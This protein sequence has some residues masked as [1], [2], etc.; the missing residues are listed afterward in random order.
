MAVNIIKAAFK[1]IR[2]ATGAILTFATITDGQVLTRSGN[3]I[4]STASVPPS[5]A[6]GGDLSGTYPDPAVAKINGRTVDPT[7]TKGDM[8]VD[9]G[10]QLRR[11]PAGSNGQQIQYDNAEALGI[12]TV[13]PATATGNILST[14]VGIDCTTTG[15]TTTFTV[16]VGKEAI[17]TGAVI[18]LKSITGGTGG[19]KFPK[20]SIGIDAGFDDIFTNTQLTQMDNTMELFH[21]NSMGVKRVGAAAELIKFEVNQ[22][23]NASVYIVDIDL[24]GYEI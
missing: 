23:S 6:A 13:T 11:F 5:G 18:R 24:I 12:K 15:A 4:S 21:F 19:G 1:K 7:T 2:D 3:T 20:V 14:T 17:V 8:F 9:D 16:S 10:G 22:A